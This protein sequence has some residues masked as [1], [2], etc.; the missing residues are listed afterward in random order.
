MSHPK[1]PRLQVHTQ[2]T[3]RFTAVQ[4]ATKSSDQTVYQGCNLASTYE[5]SRGVDQRS[6][7]LAEDRQRCKRGSEAIEKRLQKP[8]LLSRF[9]VVLCCAC[10]CCLRQ[11]RTLKPMT[12]GCANDFATK[13][14][15]EESCNTSFEWAKIDCQP[16]FGRGSRFLSFSAD[17]CSCLVP[18]PAGRGSSTKLWTGTPLH[19]SSLTVSG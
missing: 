1:S 3:S 19:I 8:Q 4:K 18:P 9:A 17:F 12:G 2:P 6:I 11:H 15:H 16:L 14:R 5:R 7:S 10:V 13:N